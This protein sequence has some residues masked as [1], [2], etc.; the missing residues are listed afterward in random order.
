MITKNI[1]QLIEEY[2]FNYPSTKIRVRQL[3]RTLK[4]PLPSII[5]YCKELEQEGIA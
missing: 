4:L 1:K 3:E 5:R 2:F